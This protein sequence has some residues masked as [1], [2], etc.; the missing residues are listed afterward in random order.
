MIDLF[1]VFILCALSN[2]TL[3]LGSFL[4]RYI[5]I[6]LINLYYSYRETVTFIRDIKEF[7]RDFRRLENFDNLQGL[8]C[9]GAFACPSKY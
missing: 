7:M 6:Q 2:V 9:P 1:A 8:D 4:L 5:R 3:Y